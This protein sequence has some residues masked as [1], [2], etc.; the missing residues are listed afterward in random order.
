MERG[1]EHRHPGKRQCTVPYGF[2]V[3]TVM[4]YIHH[5]VR[6]ARPYSVYNKAVQHKTVSVFSAVVPLKQPV[7][8]QVRVDFGKQCSAVFGQHV[9]VSL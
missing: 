9:E 7:T 2:L 6:T 4:L 5:T 1:R 8:A 3:C